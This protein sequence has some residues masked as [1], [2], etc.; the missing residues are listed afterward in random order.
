MQFYGSMLL[1]GYRPGQP[2]SGLY[3]RSEK[4]FVARP[5]GRRK[6]SAGNVGR[7]WMA[8]RNGRW[9]AWHSNEQQDIESS[10]PRGAVRCRRACETSKQLDHEVLS[11]S[12]R[13]DRAPWIVPY[14]CCYWSDLRTNACGLCILTFSLPASPKDSTRPAA[15][16]WYGKM[17]AP[18]LHDRL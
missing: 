1:S 7:C 6:E 11:F 4:E 3:V 5:F 12:Q 14:I 10:G 18:R 13:N 9:T 2:F 15:T 8:R 17:C 16:W